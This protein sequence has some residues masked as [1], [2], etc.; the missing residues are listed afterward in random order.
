MT[1]VGSGAEPVDVVI[2]V[3]NELVTVSAPGVSVA[4]PHHG[5]SHSL[6]HSVDEIRRRR[7]GVHAGGEANLS[8]DLSL[9]RTGRL[10]AESFLPPD[11]AASLYHLLSTGRRANAPVRIGLVVPPALAGLP[12]ESLPDPIDHQPLALRPRTCFYRRVAACETRALPGP[13]RIVAAIAA[14]EQDARPVLDYE[15]E[16]R[17]ILAA[18]RS[19]RHDA[20]EV[21]VVKFATPAAIRA[22]LDGNPAHILHLSGHGSPGTLYLED[23]H[24]ASLPFTAQEFI[25]RAVPPGRLPPVVTLTACFTDAAASANSASFAATLCERGAAA[26]IAT[27]TSVT[28]RYATMLLARVYGALAQSAD[29]DVVE[30]L[31]EARREVQAELQSSHG[32][33]DKLLAAL[34]EW[35]AVTVLAGSGV[36]PVVDPTV[37][38]PAATRP[39]QPQIAG[40][41]R[42]RD[43]SAVGR[44]AELRSWPADLTAP[45]VGG[46]VIYGI[47]GVGKTTLAAE[48]TDRVLDEEPDRAPVSLTGALS[49]DDLLKAVVSSVRQHV[50]TSDGGGQ[51][52]TR[53]LDF[54]VRTDMPWSDRFMVLREQVLGHIPVVVVLDNFDVNLQPG[55]DGGYVVGDGGLASLLAAWVSDP[56]FSRLLVTSRYPFTLPGGAEQALSFRQL[57]A[58]SRAE[59]MKLAWSLPALDRLNESQLETVWRLVGGHPRSLEYLDAV[60][61]SGAARFPDVTKR[62]EA[63]VH[64]RL[65][66]PERTQ[67]L[68]ASTTLDAAIAET[69]ATASDD[70]MLDDLLDRLSGIPGAS[71]LL[72]GV[73]V[74]REPIDVNAVLVQVGEADPAAAYVPDK[75]AASE[76]L[77]DIVASSDLASDDEDQGTVPEAVMAKMAPLLDDLFRRPAPPFRPT[78]SI[79][80]QIAAC[81]HAS[82]LEASK[83]G[84]DDRFF[85]HRWTAHQLVGRAGNELARAHRQAAAYWMWRVLVWPQ[86]PSAHV[87]DLKEARYHFLQAGNIDQASEVTEAIC[88]RL[89]AL[90]DWDQETGFVR[91]IIARL[92]AASPRHATWMRRLGELARIRGNYA[93]A[94]TQYQRALAITELSDD[95]ASTAATHLSLGVLAHAKGDYNEAD[96][97]YQIALD[98]SQQ[99]SDQANLASTYYQLGTLAM[100]RGDYDE[101]ARHYKA[102]LGI[103]RQLGVR[104]R[105]PATQHALGALA[106]A[107]GDYDEAARLYRA[108]LSISA[109]LDNK[110]QMAVV[111]NSLGLLAQA[112]GDYDE[113]DRQYRTVLEISEQLSDKLQMANAY[114][115]LG[116][117]AQFRGD[118]GHA[119]SLYQTSQEISSQIDNE[120]SL[121]EVYH[122]LGVHAQALRNYDEAARQYLA[123]LEIAQRLNA[124]PSISAGYHQLGTLARLRGKY[125]EAADHLNAS[126]EIS[127]QIGDKA[128]IAATTA[129]LGVLAQ[130]RRDLDEADRCYQRALVHFQDLNDRPRIAAT[131]SNLGMLEMMRNGSHEIAIGWHVKALAISLHPFNSAALTDLMWLV[132]H[133]AAIGPASFDRILTDAAQDTSLV[134]EILTMMSIGPPRTA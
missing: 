78:G 41:I 114:H 19:A 96:R 130:D 34:G 99:R 62:L 69:V 109:Q 14:P 4:A 86:G 48:L 51:K 85:V 40:L 134:T 2:T 55:N 106:Y 54:A 18:V 7:A 5:V 60:L 116:V 53:S 21:S 124:K 25:E 61:S 122:S 24:G 93:D 81:R 44:R 13:L 35:A 33:R 10:L 71:E 127:Q 80:E 70:V 79:D 43:W 133:R 128:G 67:W 58:L 82:L 73:S 74:Y 132:M 118:L 75:R 102:S 15:Q 131:F 37:T 123:A 20:A 77:I 31:A 87:H 65:S 94:A 111:H 11:V 28:D 17:N 16:L 112:Q 100:D 32:E 108:S 91:D 63:A 97:Q 119:A 126:L 76:Q 95:Q 22:E 23:E 3:T 105:S 26:V 12:W 88:A 90:G 66:G 9:A 107:R 110:P 50:Q 121:A 103:D 38:S 101:A 125:Q 30:A 46:I 68:G 52:L 104:T 92:P 59:T 8:V 89:H 84:S 72:Y 56:G 39:S 113:A 49:V 1:A 6:T 45:A 115:N 36:V 129:E 98:M 83:G 64:R 120:R 42:S 29:A 27:E 47:G 117:I 57:G